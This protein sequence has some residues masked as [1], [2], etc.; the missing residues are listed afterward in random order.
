MNVLNC[1]SD[2]FYVEFHTKRSIYLSKKYVI[3]RGWGIPKGRLT[4]ICRCHQV[5]C[6]WEMYTLQLGS[7]S[8]TKSEHADLKGWADGI[9][10]AAERERWFATYSDP[11]HE[12]IW[13]GEIFSVV[14]YF[15][16]VSR[17]DFQNPWRKDTLQVQNTIGKNWQCQNLPSCVQPSDVTEQRES[18]FWVGCCL[19][20]SYKEG[21]FQESFLL[22]TAKWVKIP[23]TFS[24]FYGTWYAPITP[25][26]PWVILWNAI[27]LLNIVSLFR[28]LYL[29][30]VQLILLRD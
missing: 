8:V 6:V 30:I 2:L 11:L 1:N 29:T 14:H 28:Y 20:S 3:Q 22:L 25:F 21:S 26:S 10:S 23:Q 18:S 15:A 5:L 24:N 16:K 17:H 7:F 12:V 9:Q 27:S 4:L 13:R 19:S